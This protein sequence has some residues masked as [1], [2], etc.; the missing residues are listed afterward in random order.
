MATT[1]TNRIAGSNGSGIPFCDNAERDLLACLLIDDS[2]VPVAEKIVAVDDFV[3]EDNRIIYGHIIAADALGHLVDV[4][5]L[6]R[7]LDESG[8][9][10]RVGGQFHEHLTGK[11]VVLRVQ[12]RHRCGKI[13]RIVT[14]RHTRQQS[15]HRLPAI[16]FGRRLPCHSDEPTHVAGR[17]PSKRPVPDH[18]DWP[19]HLETRAS[20]SRSGLT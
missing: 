11:G 19:N 6:L 9:L 12:V 13:Y 7:Q 17:W 16:L 8:D 14:G 1:T 5:L 20:S 3:A 15:S 2:Q 18:S 4:R 10:E